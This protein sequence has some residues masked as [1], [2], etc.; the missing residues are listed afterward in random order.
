MIFYTGKVDFFL[1]ALG[2]SRLQEQLPPGSVKV[3]TFAF[4]YHLPLPLPPSSI[5]PSHSL[6]PCAPGRFL[7]PSSR[8]ESCTCNFLTSKCCCGRLEKSLQI[9]LKEGSPE[10]HTSSS[11]SQYQW[12]SQRQR[13][14][15]DAQLCRGLAPACPRGSQPQAIWA[16]LFYTAL[17]TAVGASCP[18][19]ARA[20]L[21]SQ[22]SPT[23]LFGLVKWAVPRHWGQ[24]A[25]LSS[26][27]CV[28]KSSPPKIRVP[29]FTVLGRK[30]P[31]HMLLSSR[32]PVSAAGSQY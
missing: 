13:A 2:D 8:H 14:A 11:S 24:K 32:C 21:I 17:H 22:Q 20:Q 27:L 5:T 10:S 4:I 28:A 9:T 31:W 19:A 23:G 29:T 12:H 18:G 26:S 1:S 16:G 30:G 3:V 6:P 25:E 7:C 15:H